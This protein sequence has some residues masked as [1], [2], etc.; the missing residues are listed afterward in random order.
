MGFLKALGALSRGLAKTRGR[1]VSG[2]RGLVSLGRR[3]DE[4]LLSELEEILISA[5]VG[6]K[7]AAAICE[8]VREAGL[9]PLELVYRNLLALPFAVVLRKLLRG[10]PSSSGEPESD[11]RPL[12]PWIDAALFALSP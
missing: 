1:I 10:R 3:V 12:P 4:D 8:R 9:E 7:S 6:P 5:D 2:L 11:L